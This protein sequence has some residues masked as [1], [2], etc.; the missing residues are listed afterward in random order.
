MGK[1]SLINLIAG[2][3][4][5]ETSS[6]ALGCTLEYQRHLLDLG[7][8]KVAIWDTAGLDEGTQGSVPADKA[9]AYLKQLLHALAK[10]D[11]VDLL[12]Y[13]VRG[14]RVRAALLTNYHIFYSAICRKKVPIAI[15]IT[16][17]ENQEGDMETWWYNNASQFTALK[18][19]FYGHACVTTLEPLVENPIVDER[20]KISR[21]AVTKMIINT[22]RAQQWRPLERSWVE[23]AYSD[24]RAMLSPRASSN[25]RLSTIIM[26]EAYRNGRDNQWLR[27]RSISFHNPVTLSLSFIPLNIRSPITISNDVSRRKLPFQQG[28]KSTSHSMYRVYQVSS[29]VTEEETKWATV[30][31]RGA[32]LLIFCVNMEGTD[33][34]TLNS[35]WEYF[36]LT[37]G[38][39]LSPRIVVVIG[40]PDKSSAETWWKDVVGG[41]LIMNDVDIACLPGSA[42]VV[43]PEEAQQQLQW[44]IN[45]RCLDLGKVAFTKNEGLLP[46]MLR[47]DMSYLTS[48]WEKTEN[49]E[50]DAPTPVQDILTKLR[51]WDEVPESGLSTLSP[52]SVKEAQS[53]FKF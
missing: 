51:V 7:D 30:I 22:C 12:I 18:M 47:L 35:Q 15:V 34:K 44:L 43:T 16:G 20:R 29:E 24:I 36:N 23:S 49:V 17:L 32:D 9:E 6:G 2:T 53:H 45:D 5:T 48:P 19:F 46:R 38:G 1:S 39:D 27:K 10:H 13:C 14:S 3:K 26:C 4:V 40:A 31:K 21:V 11:G 25:A 33:P 41:P 52:V 8:D 28:I 50:E 37:Y 42:A